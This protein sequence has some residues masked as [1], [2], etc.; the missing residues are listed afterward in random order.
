VRDARPGI[1]AIVSTAETRLMPCNDETEPYRAGGRR[2]VKRFGARAHPVCHSPSVTPGPAPVGLTEGAAI[3][4]LLRAAFPVLSLG[5]GS[6]LAG[7]TSH[8]ALGGAGWSLT[9]PTA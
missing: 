6:A 5:I 2:G 9:A 4:L 7:L 3:K 8:A 1:A